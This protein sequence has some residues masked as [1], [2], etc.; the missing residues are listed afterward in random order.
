MAVE[1]NFNKLIFLKKF[2][3]YFNRKIIGGENFSNYVNY[4][5][6]QLVEIALTFGKNDFDENK[7]IIVDL[8]VLEGIKLDITH[9]VEEDI[10]SHYFFDY[11]FLEKKLI[12]TC[13]SLYTLADDV[14]IKVNYSFNQYEYFELK[15]FNFN[16]NEGIFSKVIINNALDDYDYLLVLDSEDNIVSR[17]FILDSTRTRKNQFEMNI[18]RDI[19]YDYLYDL[20]ES[21]I[22]VQKGMLNNDDPFILNNE[23]MSF[24]QVK[25]R[26][27]KL[28]DNS[29]IPWIVIYF[30]R[31]TAKRAISIDG[32]S[33]NFP[34]DDHIHLKDQEYDAVFIPYGYIT[35]DTKEYRNSPV[36][37]YRNMKEYAMKIAQAIAVSL[38]AACYDI[39]LLPYCPEQSIID[40][41]SFPVKLKTY[42]RSLDDVA[43]Y[44]QKIKHTATAGDKGIVTLDIEEF[45]IDSHDPENIQLI[46]SVEPDRI[47][48]DAN[49]T[50]T[51]SNVQI[52]SIYGEIGT[53]TISYNVNATTKTVNVIIG[54]FTKAPSS[55]LVSFVWE[56]ASTD[57]DCWVSQILY[58][59][60]SSFEVSNISF[61]SINETDL[62][63]ASNCYLAR[64]VSPNYQGSFDLN[65]GKNGGQVGNIKAYCTYKPFTPTIKVVPEFK[66]LYGQNYIDNRGLICG[67]DYSLPRITDAWQTFQLN[68]KNYQNIFNREIQNMD[69]NY[70]IAMRNQVITGAVGVGTATLGGAAAGAVAGSIVP[71][72]GTAIGAAVGAIGGAITSGIGMAVDTVTMAEQYKENRDLAIDKFNYQLGN[73]KALPYTLTKVSS[74]DII[75]KIFPFLEVYAPTQKEMDA[76]ELKIKYESMTVLRI[77]KM[78]NF[79]HKFDDLCYF[80][81]ELI[82]NETIATNNRVIMA[83]Y[84]ELLKG[85]YI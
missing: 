2:N 62:K 26:E 18:K 75:S 39:Q 73:I 34:I 63:K 52:D 44:G 9:E 4:P 53:P 48:A 76:F 57:G 79:Y 47:K 5:S 37:S 80:K 27:E 19:I 6:G 38:D 21:P 58:M 22:Y 17:W 35:L 3:N 1:T 74:F 84:D 81:G 60:Q 14:L 23:G 36:V 15:N 7:Q 66:L 50:L 70:D 56:I 12:I 28:E 78:S 59:D 65:I 49:C 77:D 43:Y 45:E 31:N 25:V 83:L 55:I 13:G 40:L 32:I 42:R 71:G 41:D 24:N 54:G 33:F 20:M 61:N 85:V 67:G 16:P 82:R 46:A 64:L 30:A 29:G 11:K 72:I 8:E 51:I 68:N 10:P 69:F